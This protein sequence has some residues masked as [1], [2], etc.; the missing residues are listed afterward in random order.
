MITAIIF[1]VVLL[2]IHPGIWN[3]RGFKLVINTGLILVLLYLLSEK[4]GQTL[5]FGQAPP[6]LQITSGGLEMGLRTG[7]R[8]LSIIFLSYIVIL[9]TQPNHL[10]YSLMQIGVP[11]R[12]GFM[13]VTA[14]RL[15]PILEEEGKTIYQAQLVRGVKY[16]QKNIKKIIIL[17]K[18]FMTP[19]LFSALRKADKLVFSMEGRGFGKYPKRSFFDQT[20]HSYRDY[21]VSIGLLFFFISLLI[22]DFGG[23]V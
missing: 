8:F 16:D 6:L 21:Y 14:L 5:L 9:T 12:Y 4:S 3:T 19:L 10:A 11:Y 13:L 18:Q 20:A 23:I 2:L 7:G 17:I 22:L 15:A 1:L